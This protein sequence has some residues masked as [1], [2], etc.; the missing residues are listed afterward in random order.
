MK[1]D[2]VALNGAYWMQKNSW[3][4]ICLKN[5]N[6]FVIDEFSS[7]TLILR[8]R[9]SSLYKKCIQF[10]LYPSQLFSTCYVHEIMIPCQLPTISE[11]ICSAFQF[12]V[13]L[14]QN[15]SWNAWKIAHDVRKGLKSD[16]VA[17]DGAY[18]MQKNSWVK[19]C[20]KNWNPFVI[21]E[22]SSEIL[23]LRKRLSILYTKCIQFLP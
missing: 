4:K 11:F 17:L 20:L 7:E 12:R 6:P 22:F 10:F 2:D 5:W 13:I 18:W 9:L 14:A 1:S 23:I 3:V 8:N 21:D 16:D 15:K 19:I